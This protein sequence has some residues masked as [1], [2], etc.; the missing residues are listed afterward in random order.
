MKKWRANSVAEKKKRNR[1]GLLA[2]ARRLV[3]TAVQ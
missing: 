3:E 2:A 1:D